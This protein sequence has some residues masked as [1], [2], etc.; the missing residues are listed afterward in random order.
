M[1]GTREG[2]ERVGFLVGWLVSGLVGRRTASETRKGG[3]SGSRPQGRAVRLEARRHVIAAA[4][5]AWKQ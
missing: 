4:K 5:E 3:G 1:R 2:R